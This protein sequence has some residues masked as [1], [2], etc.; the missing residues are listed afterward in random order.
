MNQRLKHG[1]FSVI[2]SSFAMII[3]LAG[4]LVIGRLNYQLARA[5]QEEK[6]DPIE[7]KD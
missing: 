2:N 4:L 7:H 1:P 6:L 3:V 5:E